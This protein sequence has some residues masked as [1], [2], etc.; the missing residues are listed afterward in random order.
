M[1]FRPLRPN[2]FWKNSISLD[3]REIFDPI[4]LAKLQ[5]HILK[6]G[7]FVPSFCGKMAKVCANKFG[8][9]LSPS[10]FREIQRAFKIQPSKFET[11]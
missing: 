6:V 9:Y 2:A 4:F 1:G 8:K 11:F 10:F 5:V 3:N 7:E